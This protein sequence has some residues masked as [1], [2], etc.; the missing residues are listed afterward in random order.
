MDKL[1]LKINKTQLFTDQAKIELLTR[2]EEIP[3]A[4]QAVLGD[5]IDRFDQERRRAGQKMREHVAHELQ[6]LHSEAS[7]EERDDVDA[8]IAQM[9][10]GVQILTE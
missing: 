4:E 8:A 2:L 5:I 7:S 10:L 3:E 1:R 6:E 9:H